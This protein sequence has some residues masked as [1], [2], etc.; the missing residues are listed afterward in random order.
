MIRLRSPSFRH[1]VTVFGE[2]FSRLLGWPEFV[3]ILASIAL[4]IGTE[5]VI[6]RIAFSKDV[7]KNPKNR[8]MLYGG[9]VLNLFIRGLRILKI[10]SLYGDGSKGFVFD[11]K[12]EDIEETNRQN[13]PVSGEY[14]TELAVRTKP[15]VYVGEK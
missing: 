4:G 8:A 5:E 6:N 9:F 11:V 3:C 7:Q 2:V 12:K 13:Q 15:G 1:L 14:D 10:R